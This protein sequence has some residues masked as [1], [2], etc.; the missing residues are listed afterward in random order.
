MKATRFNPSDFHMIF[1]REY[2]NFEDN[3]LKP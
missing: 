1:D 3:Y 2:N